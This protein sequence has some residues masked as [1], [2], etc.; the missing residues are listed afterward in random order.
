MQ[1]KSSYSTF[2]PVLLLLYSVWKVFQTNIQVQKNISQEINLYLPRYRAKRICSTPLQISGTLGLMEMQP[3]TCLF[4]NPTFRDRQWTL[5]CF[6][7][8]HPGLGQQPA[9]N[10]QEHSPQWSQQFCFLTWC[11]P[12]LPLWLLWN[13]LAVNLARQVERKWVSK[14]E[15]W[16]A[17]NFQKWMWSKETQKCLFSLWKG[18][19]LFN[20]F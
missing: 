8:Q 2:F 16:L 20:S 1:E 6:D 11:R 7:T 14:P 5:Y 4:L 3:E 17:S 19:I 10:P 18:T 9:L 15:P 12:S 13:N